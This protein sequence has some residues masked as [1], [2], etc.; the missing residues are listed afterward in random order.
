[1]GV[2]S[3]TIDG[4]MIRSLCNE[5]SG[6]IEEGNPVVISQFAG[7]GGSARVFGTL[8]DCPGGKVT[9]SVSVLLAGRGFSAH[10]QA[11]NGPSRIWVSISIRA[12]VGTH[13]A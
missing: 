8:F 12:P 10:G 3:K 4:S 6:C 5:V 13:R 2:F 7:D 9:L 1:L 11:N